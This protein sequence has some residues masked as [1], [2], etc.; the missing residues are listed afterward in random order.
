MSP[1]TKFPVRISPLYVG[2]L[3]ARVEVLGTTAVAR[4]AGLTPKTVWRQLAGG[5]GRKP[6]P[7]AIDAIRRAVD[8]LEPGAEP[9]PPPL[10][11]VR[12]RL[13]HEWIAL[14]DEIAIGD[15]ARVIADVTKRHTRRK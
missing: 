15:L 5:E 11:A 1:P 12:G 7:S 6:T 3:R 2:E 10:V 9:M 14:A 8:K 4:A 13:H